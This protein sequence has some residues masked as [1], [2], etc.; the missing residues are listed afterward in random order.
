V[1]LRCYPGLAVPQAESNSQF[2]PRTLCNRKQSSMRLITKSAIWLVTVFAGSA[3]ADVSS[4]SQTLSVGLASQIK[5]VSVPSTSFLLPL[6]TSFAGF[7]SSIPISFRVR[8]SASGV[9]T[10]TLSASEFVP[11]SG[12]KIGNG[13]LTYSCSGQTI[14]TPCG[15]ATS[16]L[17]NVQTSVVSV[18]AGACTGG[19][20]VCSSADPNSTTITF[21]LKDSPTFAATTYASTIV[22]TA[23]AL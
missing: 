10:I 12:P 3:L 17:V 1:T 21:T 16:M 4:V 18:G 8:T 23:S 19:G 13:D 9:G 22:F 6:S 5:I 15:N 14:G 11:S 20:G 7:S 2:I